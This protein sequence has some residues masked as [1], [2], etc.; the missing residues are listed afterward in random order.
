MTTQSFDGAPLA[1]SMAFISLDLFIHFVGLSMYFVCCV[2]VCQF[3]YVYAC[4]SVY[5]YVCM[6]VY[7]MDGM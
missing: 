4:L 5:M 6:Y 1:P 2:F 7:V 3:V